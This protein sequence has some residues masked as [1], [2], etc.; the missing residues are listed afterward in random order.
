VEVAFV[1]QVQVMTLVRSVK[2]NDIF[3]LKWF[4]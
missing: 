2:K 1:Y 3:I 4:T